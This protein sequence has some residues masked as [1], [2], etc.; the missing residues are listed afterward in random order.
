[1]RLAY[2]PG[3]VLDLQEIR[4]HYLDQ[5]GPVL[6]QRMVRDI[7]DEVGRLASN[8]QLAPAYDLVPGVR[9]LVVAGGAYL[10]FYR[11]TDAVQ[12]LHVRRSERRPADSSDLKG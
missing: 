4:Q 3:A 5:G 8:P 9:R 2:Q 7:R 10:A 11:I 1:M 12:I 6:A